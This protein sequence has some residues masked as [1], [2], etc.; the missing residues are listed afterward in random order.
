MAATIKALLHRTLSQKR[1]DSIR[2]TV[3]SLRASCISPVTLSGILYKK[4]FGRKLDWDHPSTLNEWIAW[5]AFKT[6]TS[7]W[8]MLADKYRVRSFV[9]QRGLG[10]MLVQLYGMWERADDIDFDR[11]PD[12]FVLKCNNGYGDIRIIHDKTTVD[13]KEIKA[14]MA[15]GLKRKFGK[16][17][18]EPHYLAIR[19]CIIAEELLPVDRQADESC[20][21]IDYKI[22]CVGGKPQFIL[23]CYDRESSER[24]VLES[25]DTDWTFNNSY[26]RSNSQFD[27]GT[28]RLNRP[29]SLDD[30]L[31]A[32]RILSAG[33][34]QARID[35]YNVGDK[36][37]FGE[38]TLTSAGGR[39]TYLSDAVQKE[40]GAKIARIVT[41]GN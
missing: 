33:L 1:Y 39:M 32:A 29:E 6:D 21:L 15:A 36:A 25:Y 12:S 14:A 37:Y 23:V 38:I 18:A 40:L 11:L 30:M 35:F 4:Q 13:P 34:P 5:L 9:K 27:L 8:T 19:P 7:E 28:R 41:C 20:S 26:L 31:R 10:H 22:W 16:I 17:T 3:F 2:Q 24:V